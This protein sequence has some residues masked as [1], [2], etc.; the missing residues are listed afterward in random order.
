MYL[1]F[2]GDL[3]GKEACVDWIGHIRN[4]QKFGSIDLLI[5]EMEK[6]KIRAKE[7]LEAN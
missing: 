4:E 2:D 3:Y 7:I 1:D 5:E 6:D